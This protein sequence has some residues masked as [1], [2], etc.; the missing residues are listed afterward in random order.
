MENG[1][2]AYSKPPTNQED[3]LMSEAKSKKKP[4]WVL[5][6]REIFEE[7][8]FLSVRSSAFTDA[9]HLTYWSFAR[10]RKKFRGHKLSQLSYFTLSS[11]V[12]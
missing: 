1:K 6:G 11:R 8:H 7:D 9:I 3:L 12:Q 10:V 2:E 4:N 5:K